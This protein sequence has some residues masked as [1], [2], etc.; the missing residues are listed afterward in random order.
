MKLTHADIDS[1]NRLSLGLIEKHGLNP[2]AALEKLQD[3]R[4]SIVGDMGLASSFPLQAALATAV[5]TGKR[6]FL[7]GVTLYM[8]KDIPSLLN[9]PGKVTL[10]EVATE[11]GA[12]CVEES[13]GERPDGS[14]L[15]S[16]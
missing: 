6:A 9:W 11:L 8:P 14:L 4:L 7:G 12:E 13:D 16:D 2:R 3:F 1:F 15:I 5:N 10:N